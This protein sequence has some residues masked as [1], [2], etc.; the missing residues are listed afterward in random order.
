M[1]ETLSPIPFPF[2]EP[3]SV[4]EL[5]PELSRIREERSVAEVTLPDGTSAWLVT[6]YADVRK[7]L[8]DPR[9][10]SRVAAAMMAL[11]ESELGKLTNE[12]LIGTDP[13]QHTRL[14]KLV[15]REFTARRVEEMR[16]RVARMVAELLDRMESLPRPVDLVQNFSLPLPVRVICDLLG[17]P[18]ADQGE[19]HKW[20]NGL[21][22][23]WTRA[24]EKEEAAV[25]LIAYLGRLIV[26][27]RNNPA[28]D[29]LSA[30]IR[31]KDDEDKLS[32][33]ELIAL[34]IG[35]LSAGH[36][37]T[38]NQINMFLLTLLRF[39]EEFARLRA[40][41]DGI[42]RA[43]EELLRFVPIT[44]TGDGLPRITTAEVEVN[45]V[46]IPAGA[47]VIPSLA[48]ANR[49]PAVFDNPD[50][51][52]LDRADNPQV[53]FG[54]GI[55]HCLGAQLARVELQE[56]LSALFRRMPDVR[57]AVPESELRRKSSSMIRGL[58]SMPITW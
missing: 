58:E 10:S 13:P 19:F 35:L 5:S 25:A 44:A 50:Q 47:I 49:D 9:F 12:S 43:V 51:L 17:V 39:P 57:L 3:P 42:P 21:L 55:H 36:E 8:V 31:A 23:D 48:A 32:E 4:Y 37:T 2:P 56:T 30:L 40:N 41:P 14:R 28:D 18:A 7:V 38:A 52:N 16:P 22:G 27:K 29:L 15:S 46:T 26:D 1:A 6:R 54:A 20:S 11:S 53:G 24:K 34:G 33:R 45:G